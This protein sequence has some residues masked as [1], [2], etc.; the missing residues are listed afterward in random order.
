LLLV[1]RL[2]LAPGF[3]LGGP[4]TRLGTSGWTVLA[5]A[6]PALVVMRAASFERRMRPQMSISHDA[7]SQP[8]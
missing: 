2:A 1:L 6:C 4:G 8:W 3:T 5:G 7:V